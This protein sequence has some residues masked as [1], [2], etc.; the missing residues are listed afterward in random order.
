MAL[1]VL[2][3]PSQTDGSGSIVVATWNISNGRNGR[4]ESALRSMEAM[5]IDLGVFLEIKLMGRIYTWNS[6]Q[7]S[8][9]ASDVPSAH[10][11]GIALFWRANKTYKVKDR[12]IHGPNMLS[13]VI[14]M[15][16]QHFYVVGC[17][18]PPNNLCTLPQVKQALN[19]CPKGHTPL[20]IGDLNVNLHA[21]W[22]ERDEQIAEVVEDLCGLTNRP[23]TSINDPA[24]THGGDGHGG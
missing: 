2:C 10:Q 5:G 3:L 12:C 16:S 19:K 4:L 20:F 23:N 18:I 11:G 8:V 21:P 22:D 15:G 17:Y 24:V 6:S 14:V 9:V 1:T 13:F 7:Y